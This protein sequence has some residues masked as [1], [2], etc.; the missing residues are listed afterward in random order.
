MLSG[1]QIRT[2]LVGSAMSPAQR[3]LCAYLWLSI[4][5]RWIGS[6]RA[7]GPVVGEAIDRSPAEGALA[8][9]RIWQDTPVR[10]FNGHVRWV[11]RGTQM[12]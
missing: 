10:A 12:Q 3:S 11:S 4:G 7:E 1:V 5:L 2:E 9:H 6:E 8:M